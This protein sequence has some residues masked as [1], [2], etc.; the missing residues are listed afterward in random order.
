MLYFLWQVGEE[1]GVFGVEDL[2]QRDEDTDFDAVGAGFHF[3]VYIA[4]YIAL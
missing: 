1:I 4:C 3:G 2:L